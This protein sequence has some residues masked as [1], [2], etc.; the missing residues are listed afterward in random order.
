LILQLKDLPVPETVEVIVE[1]EAEVEVGVETEEEIVE[2]EAGVEK[3]IVHVLALEIEIDV[4][5]G[6]DLAL[7]PE[8]EEITIEEEIEEET[9]EEIDNQD[10]KDATPCSLAI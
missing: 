6:P 4:L 2:T 8:I 9:E 5:T 1:T 10:L 3:D 7:D